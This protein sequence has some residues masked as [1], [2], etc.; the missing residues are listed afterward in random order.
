ML[1]IEADVIDETSESSS[2]RHDS[3]KLSNALAEG[4]RKHRGRR[5]RLPRVKLNLDLGVAENQREASDIYHDA[6]NNRDK[7]I[8]ESVDMIYNWVVD[9]LK[10]AFNPQRSGTR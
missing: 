1:L 6:D 3:L 8:Q 5:R 9:L 4:Y 7:V 2:A 10:W